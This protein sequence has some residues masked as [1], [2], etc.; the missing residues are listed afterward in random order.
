MSMHDGTHGDTIWLNSLDGELEHLQALT[1]RRTKPNSVPNAL[2]IVHQIPVY[3]GDR[4]RQ[5]TSAAQTHPYAVKDLQAEW[6]R[7]LKNGAGVIAIRD[8]IK[9]LELLDEVSGVLQQIMDVE[10]ADRHTAADHFAAA[11]RIEP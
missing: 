1:Q 5:V 7:V 11:E 2:D 6:V 8:A 9:D 4:V 10:S 3:H